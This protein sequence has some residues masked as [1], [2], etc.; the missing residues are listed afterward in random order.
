[1]TERVNERDHSSV[2]P[3]PFGARMF[4]GNRSPITTAAGRRSGSALRRRVAALLM[5]VILALPGCVSAQSLVP[6]PVPD[7]T[8]PA[9]VFVADGAGN[10]QIASR[11][12]R[13]VV[14]CDGYPLQIITFDW[15]HGYG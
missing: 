14:Q 8:A 10:F 11:N 5:L 6:H 9:T 12:L 13:A 1:M 4:V 2:I 15:S 3:S 7:L